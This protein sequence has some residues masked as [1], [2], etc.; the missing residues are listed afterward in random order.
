M[1]KW[2]AG[3]QP[4]RMPEETNVW[5]PEAT[6]HQCPSC[7]SHD[8]RKS[9]P[10]GPIDAITLMFNCWPYRCRKCSRRFVRRLPKQNAMDLLPDDPEEPVEPHE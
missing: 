3:K 5:T 8:T 1:V 4:V 6:T 10:G 9:L 7:G 2:S